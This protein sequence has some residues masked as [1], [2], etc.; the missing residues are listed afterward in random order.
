MNDKEKNG[1]VD[2][3]GL[4]T[5]KLENSILLGSSDTA[6]PNSIIFTLSGKEK[7]K[8]TE[9]GFFVEGRLVENDKEIYQQ[10]KSFIEKGLV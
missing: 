1:W 7:I 2:L 8:I 3:S 5:I 10:F 9:E 6:A 4:N